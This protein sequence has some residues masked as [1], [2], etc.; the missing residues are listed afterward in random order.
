MYVELAVCLLLNY[1]PGVNRVSWRTSCKISPSLRES[2][3]ETVFG[4]P[5][6]NCCISI[7]LIMLKRKI[8]SLGDQI[9]SFQWQW[10]LKAE[11]VELGSLCADYK[12]FVFSMNR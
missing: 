11:E 2:L 1:L 6:S 3:S 12:L 4:S 5:Y 8:A 7:M 10:K 9:R